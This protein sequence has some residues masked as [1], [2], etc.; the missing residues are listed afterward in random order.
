MYDYLVF[1]GR[2]QPF[3]N[4]HKAV[5]DQALKQSEKVIVLVGSA[6]VARSQRNPFTWRERSDMIRG[7]FS[8]EE[9]RRII[10]TPILDKKYNE[11]AWVTNVQEC[12]DSWK[13]Q[14]KGR[15][16]KIGLIGLEKDHS[17]YYLKMF[18]QWGSVNV[19]QDIILSATD[20]RD[21][22][23]NG[24]NVWSV[25]DTCRNKLPDSTRAFLHTFSN[26]E[27]YGRLVKEFKVLSKYK[28]SWK[29][30][31]YPPIFVTTDAVVI[32]SGHI[33]LVQRGASP[34]KGLFAL[35]GGFINSNEKVVDSMIRE[36]REETKLKIPE[37]V[38]RG[39]ITKNEV[40]DDPYRSD[41]GRTITHAYLIELR[42]DVRGLPKV[43]G[44]DDAAHAM[45]VPLS[46]LDP[47]LLFEDH[48]D[49]VEELIGTNLFNIKPLLKAYEQEISDE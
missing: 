33:L 1:I 6:K 25:S 19:E 11:N 12:V 39:S 48:F 23:F 32:Q 31:P 14:S 44:G 15:D 22:Y 9:R 3:H 41:R 18:P 8:K 47:E 20:I 27:H 21:L 46:S 2:F 5:I 45:W 34:G 30:S 26:T 36:L 42:G 29:R 4:G 7:A 28:E 40:F 35:P 43:A 38:L 24:T 37:P 49:I 13:W 10:V 17:S 16:T